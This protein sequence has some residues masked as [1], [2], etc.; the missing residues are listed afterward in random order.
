MATAAL[1][2]AAPTNAMPRVVVLG[3]GNVTRSDDAL[4]PLLLRR[5][6]RARLQHVTIVEDFQLQPEHAFDLGGHDLA[7][8]VDAGFGMPE[9]F[10][11]FETAPRASMAFSSHKMA[12]EA[13]L[14]IHE[15]VLGETPPPAFILSVA[16]EDFSVGDTLSAAAAQRLEL[17]SNFLMQRLHF[18]SLESWRAAAE[19]PCPAAALV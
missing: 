14:D 17:A 5:V 8:F 15:R 2:D 4:G 9:P 6:R 12:P 3:W 7:L 11:F 16:G 1:V 13:V 18:P 10:A 19:T